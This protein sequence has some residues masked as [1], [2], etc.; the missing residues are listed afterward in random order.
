MYRV[1][2]L[3]SVLS[4]YIYV[5]ESQFTLLT[6]HGTTIYFVTYTRFIKDTVYHYTDSG[7][8]VLR[9][10]LRLVCCNTM[11]ITYR[12]SDHKVKAPRVNLP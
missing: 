9:K 2:V 7:K 4:L 6:L 11:E 5:N 3:S 10:Q 1:R 8:G 12:L